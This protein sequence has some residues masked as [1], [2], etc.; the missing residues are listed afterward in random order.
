MGTRPSAL[1]V[2][3]A[4]SRLGAVVALLPPG[5]NLDV[6]VHLGSI[7][8]IVADPENLNAALSTGKQVLVLGG[9]DTRT[10]APLGGGAIDLELI[11][12]EDVSL[13]GW[14]RPDPGL[15]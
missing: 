2:I 8:R 3:S 15:A 5:S 9:G 13:P 12:P 7:E 6:A 14:Y 1:A 11:D 10:H 4:L